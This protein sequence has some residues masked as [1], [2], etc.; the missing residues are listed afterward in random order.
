MASPRRVVIAPGRLGHRQRNEALHARS[1][2]ATVV[3]CGASAAVIGLVTHSVLTS[4]AAVFFPA[5]GVQAMAAMVFV[6]GLLVGAG[7]R[8]VQTRSGLCSKG[9]STSA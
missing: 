6:S 9:I 4:T 2:V 7:L 3:L 8:L 1:R 5:L